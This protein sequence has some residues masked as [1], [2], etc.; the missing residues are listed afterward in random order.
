MTDEVSGFDYDVALSFAGEDRAEAEALAAIL[1]ESGIRVFYD[2]YEA[3]DLWGKDL[4]QHL[5]SVYKDRSR[6]CVMILSRHYAEKLWTRH[7]LQQAQAR[8][9]R[10][11]RE[12]I[13]PLRKDDTAI[14]GVP[15]TIGY[16]DLRET[17][18][19]QAAR[20][21]FEKLGITPR[22]VWHDII[23]RDVVP[24]VK[25]SLDVRLGG[26]VSSIALEALARRLFDEHKGASF[27]RMFIC[28][29][30]P[31]MELNAGA[32]ATTHFNP[33]LD[34]QILG[35]TLEQS[36]QLRDRQPVEDDRQIVG[37]WMQQGPGVSGFVTIFRQ[38]HRVYLEETFGDGSQLSRELTESRANGETR[39]ELK[40]R[41]DHQDYWVLDRSGYLSL[42]DGDGWVMRYL[43]Y[44]DR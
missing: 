24:G 8:A 34:V 23:S 7:E 17:P 12:Y 28:Y 18:L 36:E 33:D 39:F 11:N 16:I 19:H 9:F 26:P 37:R 31:G 32:W 44:P 10:E 21:V 15:E 13:L 42:R 3:A 29:L 35:M 40:E 6:F 5:A 30:L 20:L 22:Q 2:R 14:P 41:N 4:Y 38:G 27:A 1:K 25:C 43:L